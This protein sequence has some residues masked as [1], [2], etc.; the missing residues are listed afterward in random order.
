MRSSRFR[1]E[2]L[3]QRTIEGFD[4]LGFK[5]TM[6]PPGAE[7]SGTVRSVRELWCSEELGAVL[8]EVQP[9]QREMKHETSMTKVERREPDAS[10]FDIPADYTIEELMNDRSRSPQTGPLRPATVPP[11]P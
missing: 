7:D 5:I 6:L 2:G 3:G 4:T 10:L 11:K 1:I 8:L 9:M